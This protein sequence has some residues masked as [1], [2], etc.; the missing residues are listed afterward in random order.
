MADCSYLQRGV[1]MVCK[2]AWF[3]WLAIVTVGSLLP[4]QLVP[5]APVNDKTEHFVAYFVLGFLPP[6]FLKRRRAVY[7]SPLLIAALGVSLEV[8]Q[9]LSVGRSFDLADIRANTLGLLTG[10]AFGWIAR[11][12]SQR[13]AL[14]STSC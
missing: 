1:A 12:A 11:I 5:A 6:L 13:T 3:C 10:F 8:A 7:C 14:C 9:L 2:A 4:Q